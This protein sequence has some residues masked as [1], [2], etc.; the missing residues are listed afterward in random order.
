MA[1]GFPIVHQRAGHKVAVRD[2]PGDAIA[3]S[4]ASMP[5]PDVPGSPDS[6]AGAR[7]SDGGATRRG[8]SQLATQI[9]PLI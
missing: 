5:A 2:V 9:K 6:V 7:K 4:A 1:G 8:L 3:V